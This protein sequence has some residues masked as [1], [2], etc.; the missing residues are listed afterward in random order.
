MNYKRKGV[1]KDVAVLLE[2]D[3]R[4]TKFKD[5]SF[6]KTI[7][8]YFENDFWAQNGETF[9]FLSLNQMGQ[10]SYESMS[11]SPMVFQA[12]VNTCG[13]DPT[14]GLHFGRDSF[15][16]GNPVH[17]NMEFCKT[18]FL[19]TCHDDFY[20]WTSKG[21]LELAQGVVN[22]ITALVLN[23]VTTGMY[24]ALVNGGSYDSK[25]ATNVDGVSIEDAKLFQQTIGAH[26]GIIPLLEKGGATAKLSY[27]NVNGVFKQEHLDDR[28]QYL[29]SVVKDVKEVLISNANPALQSDITVNPQN[30]VMNVDA[31]VYNKLILDEKNQCH[32]PML[33]CNKPISKRKEGKRYVYDIDG[34]VV[35]PRPEATYY[36]QFTGQTSLFASI[37]KKKSFV[38]GG[39]VSKTAGEGDF[40]LRFLF[41]PIKDTYTLRGDFLFVSLIADKTKVVATQDKFKKAK[42][43]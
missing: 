43:A 10:F 7:F 15:K 20:T 27:W 12:G 40:G 23:A 25:D 41:D 16:G 34:I 35:V 30:Y 32:N 11:M 21:K 17:L 8:E 28:N 5:S 33:D 39:S 14:K 13:A 1:N 4:N 3:S 19:A 6:N 38:I 31:V 9:R 24:L 18:D 2:R 42:V 29:G 37:S 26:T 36:D 22:A